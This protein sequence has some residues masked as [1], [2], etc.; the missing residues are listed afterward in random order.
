MPASVVKLLLQ[1]AGLPR[2]FL[3]CGLTLGPG[4]L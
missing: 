3:G 4:I 1:A 2:D